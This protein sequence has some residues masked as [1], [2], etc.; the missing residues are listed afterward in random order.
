MN[1][2]DIAHVPSVKVS[3]DATVI[4]AIEAS[5][6]TRVGAVAVVEEDRLI[7]MFTERDVML[8]IVLKGLD[9]KATPLRGVMTS[10]VTTVQSQMPVGDVLRLMLERRIRHLPIS[11]DGHT[12]QGM[13]SIRNVLQYMVEDLQSD[14]RHMESYLGTSLPAG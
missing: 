13:L 4:E 8:K 2:L 12:V 1:L 5:V 7:G 9:P 10:P 14:L 3:P 6:P 11:E